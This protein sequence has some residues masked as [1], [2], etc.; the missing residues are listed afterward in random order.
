MDG[1]EGLCG[2]FDNETS[3]EVVSP[4]LFLIIKACILT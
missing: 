4:H 3:A 1:I 2:S